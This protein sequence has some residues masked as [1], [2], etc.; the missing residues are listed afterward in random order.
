MAQR[1]WH[2]IPIVDCGEPLVPLPA[3]MRR[4][5]PHPYVGLGA[6]YGAAQ[7]PFQLRSGVVTRVMRAQ[8]LLQERDR[9]L[10]LAIFDGWRPLAVQRFMVDHTLLSLCQQRGVDAQ[11]A[12]PQREAI[13]A[14]VA[15]FWAPPNSDPAAPPPHSTGAA[16]DLTL[17]D[18]HGEPLAMGGAIDAI[19]P[20]S[21]PEHYARAAMAAPASEAACWHQ[22]RVWLAEAMQAAGFARHPNEWWHFSHGDQLWAWSTGATEAHYGRIEP[23]SGGS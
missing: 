9:G 21:E 23:G 7:S 2:R 13:A 16:V 22:R 8:Q 19:G 20:V 14:D 6:P 17:I 4:L 18:S 12:S 15:R 11:I 3:A 5:E 10:A 1:P